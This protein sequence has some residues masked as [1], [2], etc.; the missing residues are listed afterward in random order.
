MRAYCGRGSPIPTTS[1]LSLRRSN[2]TLHVDAARR[3]GAALFNV[4]RARARARG[5]RAAAVRRRD[6]AACRTV[7]LRCRRSRGGARVPVDVLLAPSCVA[8]QAA[9]AAVSRR[10]SGAERAVRRR[11]TTGAVAV[12]AVLRVGHVGVGGVGHHDD[13]EPARDAAPRGVV[14]QQLARVAARGDEGVDEA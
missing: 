9:A 13:G 1:R 3:V 4:G 7:R 5:G 14:R 11:V 12:A 8:W 10:L 2:P 6:G